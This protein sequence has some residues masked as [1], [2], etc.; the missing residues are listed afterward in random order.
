MEVLSETDQPV[1]SGPQR[2]ISR[3]PYA[4]RARVFA[5]CAREIIPSG[6]FLQARVF[7]LSPAPACAQ[8]EKA[9]DGMDPRH[10]TWTPRRS[11]EWTSP[12]GP[13]AIERKRSAKP[14]WT[15]FGGDG[16][17]LS[18]VKGDP[19]VL[20]AGPHPL[21][22]GFPQTGLQ[23]PQDLGLRLGGGSASAALVMEDPPASTAPRPWSVRLGAVH[24]STRAPCPS[25][26]PQSDPE[27]TSCVRHPVSSRNRVR[28]L[29]H[30][31]LRTALVRWWYRAVGSLPRVLGEMGGR[32]CG[33]HER[34]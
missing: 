25:A 16:C 31:V 32:E 12:C 4:A 5:G 10:P 24:A 11:A 17:I 28:Q 15:E 18:A 30:Y 14:W 34:N 20:P 21:A 19:V 6:A 9:F 33:A 13:G 3:S 8:E 7:S 29:C 22:D 26:G 1:G 27:L 23:T 2:V